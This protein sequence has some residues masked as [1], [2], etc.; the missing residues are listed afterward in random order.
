MEETKTKTP[1][2]LEDEYNLEVIRTYRKIQLVDFVHFFYDNL[3]EL[4]FNQIVEE[5]KKT[6]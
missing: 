5:F 1:R 3:E 4:S 2:E 6:Q